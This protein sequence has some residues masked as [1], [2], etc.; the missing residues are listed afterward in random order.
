MSNGG[1]VFQYLPKKYHCYID[2]VEMESYFDKCSEHLV[3][4]YLVYFRDNSKIRGVGVK[5]A[6][7]K[8]KRHLSGFAV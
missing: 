4:R 7:V 6:V 8:I 3:N 5:D 2:S 1:N